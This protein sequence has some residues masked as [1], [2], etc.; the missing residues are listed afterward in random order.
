MREGRGGSNNLHAEW[1][2]RRVLIGPRGDM[3]LMLLVPVVVEAKLFPATVTCKGQEI[4]LLW[5]AAVAAR[6]CELWKLHRPRRFLALI[7]DLV[8]SHDLGETLGLAVVHC[9]ESVVSTVQSSNLQAIRNFRQ[10]RSTEPTQVSM[11]RELGMP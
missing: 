8:H 2:R 5:A 1:A 6:V 3:A 9:G 7:V 11:H 4:I 10:L